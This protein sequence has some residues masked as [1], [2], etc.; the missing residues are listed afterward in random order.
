MK[1][2]DFAKVLADIE[3]TS[4]RNQM[5]ELLASFLLKLQKDEV[6]PAMYMLT[7]RVA[8]SYIPLEFNF[9]TKL[10]I[11]SLANGFGFKNEILQSLMAEYGDVGSVAYQVLKE[12]D[13]KKLSNGMEITEVYVRLLELA[14]RQGKGAQE[15][16]QEIFNELVRQNDA[17]SCKY[18]SR[19]ITGK[20]RLGLSSKTTLDSISWASTSDKSRRKMLDLAYGV[21]ADMGVIAELALQRDFEALERLGVEVGVP[22][23]SKLV[24]REK[25]AGAIYERMGE[26]FFVQPKY[27][28]LRTQIHMS[29]RGFDAGSFEHGFDFGM[30]MGL[31]GKPQE[32]VRI[33]SRNMEPLTEMF[34]DIVEA[35][36]KLDVESV[37]LDAEAIGFDPKTNKFIPFQE[38]IKRKRKYDVSNKAKELPVRVFVFDVLYVDGQD[39]SQKPLSERLKI[40]E[41]LL[42]DSAKNRND[43]LVFSRSVL[44]DSKDEL[45]D[46]FR[47]Y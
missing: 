3:E 14:K 45:D 15:A 26:E 25:D 13:V 9:S 7:G 42:G 16:K 46:M 30:Q 5:T 33:F 11:K 28:G 20:L 1:F 40:L 27:D 31:L 38:T 22:V 35:V 4:S 17:L 24:E 44:V 19:I 23:A 39:V 41:N 36:G 2:R 43:V 8:P 32:N 6:R 37:V 21:R 10:L 47:S 34:P 12:M 29:R 18:I